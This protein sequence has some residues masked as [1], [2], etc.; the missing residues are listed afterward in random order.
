MKNSNQSSKSEIPEFSFAHV[1]LIYKCRSERYNLKI[2]PLRSSSPESKPVMKVPVQV[3]FKELLLGE[4][5]RKLKDT[6]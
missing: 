5:Y 4:T 6:R 2:K 3:I 1:S